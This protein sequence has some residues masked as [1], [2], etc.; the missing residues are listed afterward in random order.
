M[1]GKTGTF[2]NPGLSPKSLFTLE[3]WEH[4]IERGVGKNTNNADEL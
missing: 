4:S 1:S 2:P 3:R